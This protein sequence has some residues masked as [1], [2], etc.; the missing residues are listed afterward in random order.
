MI[1]QSEYID[2]LCYTRT[3]QEDIIYASRLAHSMHLAY[4][5]DG[6]HFQA[7]NHNS[8]VLFAKAT[9]HEDGM[10]Q[11]KSLKNPYLFPMA[12]GRF[13][14]VAVRTEADG[15]QDEESRGRSFFLLRTICCNIKK[16]D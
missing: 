9:Q 12:D 3:P 11:A 2:V 8:G 6:K 16:S 14:V 5:E 13:G 7:L 15:Q 1:I 4:S 10:L